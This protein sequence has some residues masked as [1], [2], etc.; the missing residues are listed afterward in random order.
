MQ[1]NNMRLIDEAISEEP[2]K[3]TFR[4]GWEFIILNKQF[5]LTMISVLII[6]NLLGLIPI[7]GFVLAIFSSTLALAIQIDIGRLVYETDNIE[8]FVDAIHSA[9]GESLIKRHFAPALGAYMGWMIIG[10]FLIILIEF[11]ISHMGTTEL[12]MNNNAELLALLST[13]GLPLLLILLLFSY[14][15]PLI[16]ANIIMSN[17]FQEGFLA[18]FTLFSINVWKKA[19]QTNYFKY[20]FWLG[21]VVLGAMLLFILLFSLF[22]VIPFLNILLM[23]VFVYIFMIIISVAAMMAKRMVES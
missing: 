9:N 1:E 20:M 4:L 22:S 12:I 21:L 2:I 6:L 15:Q 3:N 18:V 17:T 7:I 16:Q 5:T 8:T 23:I 11:I 19:M 13:V 14:I 10:L